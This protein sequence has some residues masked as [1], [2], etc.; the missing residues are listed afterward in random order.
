MQTARARAVPL[1]DLF[2]LCNFMS[3]GGP[4]VTKR[5][6]K[7]ANGTRTMPRNAAAAC[8]AIGCLQP[9]AN[10]A[11]NRTQLHVHASDGRCYSAS[12]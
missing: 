1:R 12:T 3:P 9:P 6:H 4:C 11:I 5:I 10:A 2:A 8:C 7:P